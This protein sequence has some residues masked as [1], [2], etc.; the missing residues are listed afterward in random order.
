MKILDIVNNIE[1]NKEV[2]DKLVETQTYYSNFMNRLKCEDEP[3]VNSFINLFIDHEAICSYRV[4]EDRDLVEMYTIDLTESHTCIDIINKEIRVNNGLQTDLI[5]KAHYILT[6]CEQDTCQSGNFRQKQ[7][8]I[9]KAGGRNPIYTPPSHKD[10]PHLIEDFVNMYNSKLK[11]SVLDH[12]FIKGSIV[13][14]FFVN[15]HPFV[16]G[17]GRVAALLQHSILNDGKEHF[18]P[19]LFLSDGFEFNKC[20]YNLMENKI[21]ENIF[22]SNH[23]NNWFLFNL[24]LIEGHIKRMEIYLDDVKS[25]YIKLQKQFTK[26]Y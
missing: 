18:K 19:N 23:W 10:I 5:K 22:D 3:F 12:A 8:V 6:K 16:N 26:R 13:H 24:E 21:H 1:I 20:K 17:N 14:Y 15:I 2:I 11:N 25:K 7:V 4:E 9:G